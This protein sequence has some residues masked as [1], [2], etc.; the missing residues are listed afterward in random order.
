MKITIVLCLILLSVY[1]YSQEVVTGPFFIRDGITYHQDTN[2]PVIGIIQSFFPNSSQIAERQTYRD[3]RP[4]GPSESFHDNGQLSNRGN[5]KDGKQ[6]GFHE[7]FDKR[8]TLTR[9]MTF[10]NVVP[11]ES[12][13]NP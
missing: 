12:N 8:G 11:V 7:Y 13:W 10:R 3:G 5:Y 6:D 9:T 2:E 4:D 1:S